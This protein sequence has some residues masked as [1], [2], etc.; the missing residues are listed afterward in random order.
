MVNLLGFSIKKREKQFPTET[1]SVGGELG[2]SGTTIFNGMITDEEYNSQL[3]TEY[4][5]P[6]LAMFN[7][8]RKSDPIVKQSLLIVMLPIMQAEWVVDNAEDEPSSEEHGK[9]LHDAFFERM[10][11]SFS[12]T[13]REILTCLPFGFSVFEKVFKIENGQVFLKKLAYRHQKTIAK[14]E[15][16]DGQPGVVQ[17]LQG[18]DAKQVSIPIEKLAIFTHEK[19]G[20]N[21]RGTSILRAAYKPWYFK[22]NFEKISAIGYERNAVGVPVFTMPASPKAE[23]VT[24]AKKIAANLRT[25][26][27]A[28]VMLPNGWEFKIEK[29]ETDTADGDLIVKRLNRE[30]LSNVLAQFLDLGSGSTGSRALSSDHSD[31]FYQA[32]QS[33][34]DSIADVFNDHII[35]QLIDLNF[36]NVTKYPTI[37]ATGIRK[38]DLTAIFNAIGQ[39]TSAKMLH[40]SVDLEN[41]VRKMLSLPELTE[42]EIAEIKQQEEDAREQMKQGQIDPVTGKPIKQPLDKTKEKK[43]KDD[44]VKANECGH[45]HSMQFAEH[46]FYREFTL[47]EAK[48]DFEHIQ[49]TL[50]IIEGRFGAELKEL[51]NAEV[52]QMLAK[53]RIALRE[54]DLV[55]IDQ[56]Y[57]EF[58]NSLTNALVRQ[59]REA[60]EYGKRTASDTLSVPL[61]A[62]D[63]Q[64]VNMM[65][66][67][68]D[69][70]KQKLTNE[71]VTNAKLSAISH[72]SLDTTVEDAVA[73]ISKQAKQMATLK[74]D[75]TASQ[76]LMGGFNQGRNAVFQANSMKIYGLQRSELL[77]SHICNYCLSMDGRVVT[78]NDAFANHDQFHYN[79]RGIWVEIGVDETDKPDIT[80]IPDELMAR[81]GSLADFKQLKKPMPLADSLA[82]KFVQSRS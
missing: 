1:V 47:A 73:A 75:L 36:N 65:A 24:K 68:A 70:I 6:G 58:A 11:R 63:E 46:G 39:A 19:E 66:T 12:N 69:T 48:V 51:M 18:A 40:G 79:C 56:L 74:A 13:L 37:R 53:I 81:V 54:K 67:R 28:Y 31:S 25:N 62:T 43:P 55:R 71:I 5:Q 61:M 49:Q 34:A 27:K 4:G 16:S 72:M 15:T 38:I 32:L 30:I 20:D 9:Y 52:D 57:S 26:E 21:W 33:V 17:Q 22:E 77:D 41:H 45:Y 35:P 7:R 82:D 42:E 44:E 76:I 8:M 10:N 64:Q 29:G 59:Q 2:G 50:D 80:G 78:G 3:N 60:F 23:D 14:F